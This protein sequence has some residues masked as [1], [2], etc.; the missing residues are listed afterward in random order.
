[1]VSCFLFFLFFPKEIELIIKW[2]SCSN[3][4]GSEW[5]LLRKT[6]LL[7]IFIVCWV[8]PAFCALRALP[9]MLIECEAEAVY[10]PQAQLFNVFY[11]LGFLA[12]F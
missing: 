10:L 9:L 6:Q 7:T 1:M 11:N 5:A 8:P 12:L 3:L 2:G 4:W